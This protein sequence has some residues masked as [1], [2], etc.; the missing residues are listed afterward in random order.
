ME[1]RDSE[2]LHT[3][4]RIRRK[5]TPENHGG[6]QNEMVGTQHA[7]QISEHINGWKTFRGF[8]QDTERG[9]ER[10]TKIY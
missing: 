8:Y 7:G 5:L 9:G 4:G 2:M 1:F 3:L 6:R 10:Y